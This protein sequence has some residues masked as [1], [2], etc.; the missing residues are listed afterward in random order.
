MTPQNL[1]QIKETYYFR[2]RISID[3][4][5]WFGDRQDISTVEKYN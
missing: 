2:T 4:R 3:L 1:Y 5:L